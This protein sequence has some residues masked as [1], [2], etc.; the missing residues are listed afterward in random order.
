M[1]VIYCPI[2]PMHME[3]KKPISEKVDKLL[4]GNLMIYPQTN[5]QQNNINSLFQGGHNNCYY[6]N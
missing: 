6:E 3:S 5:I 2:I 1:G 4:I